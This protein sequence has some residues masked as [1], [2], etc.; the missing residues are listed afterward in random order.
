M[1]T[2]TMLT[3]DT[4]ALSKAPYGLCIVVAL[5]L[6]SDHMFFCLIISSLRGPLCQ[7]IFS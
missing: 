6:A 3:L 2:K 1:R 7:H 4:S 5:L